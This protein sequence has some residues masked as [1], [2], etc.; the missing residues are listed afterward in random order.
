MPDIKSVIADPKFQAL[1][2]NEQLQVLS[3][4]DPNFAKLSP[5]DQQQV[6]SHVGNTVTIG[7]QVVNLKTGEGASNAA[8]SQ[9]QQTGAAVQPINRTAGILASGPQTVPADLDPMGTIA[10]SARAQSGL[11]IMGNL[12]GPLH[13]QSTA[14][15]QQNAKNALIAAGMA[16]APE[17]IPEVAGSGVLPTLANVGI[18]AANSGISG[19]AA[20]AIGQGVVGENPV[21]TQSLKETG[22]NALVSSL[23]G[24]GSKVL[25]QVP[26]VA[27][28]VKSGIKNTFGDLRQLLPL[29]KFP[30]LFRSR[31]Q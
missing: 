3:H 9:A 26:A 24:G 12:S 28:A 22:T 14:Q 30:N 25:E 17:I 13:Y 8:T 21:D 27:K 16:L 31:F 7:G 10:P 5:T 6:I 15:Q 19:G 18:R 29:A 11:G 1:G 2:P 20:T 4:V 23:I